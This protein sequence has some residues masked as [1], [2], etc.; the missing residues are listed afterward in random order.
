MNIFI[1]FNLIDDEN[2]FGEKETTDEEEDIGD[3][4]GEH[5]KL[6]IER[7]IYF[8]VEWSVIEGSLVC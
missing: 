2:F 8:F 7:L 3:I 4:V 5:G 6:C 1:F